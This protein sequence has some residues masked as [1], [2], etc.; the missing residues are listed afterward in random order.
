LLEQQGSP[1]RLVPCVVTRVSPLQITLLGE[2]NIPAV[3]IAGATYSLGAANALVSSPSKP[4][5]LPIA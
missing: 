1:C 2:S 4:I 5:V 3:K